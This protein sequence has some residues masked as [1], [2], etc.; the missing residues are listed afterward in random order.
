MKVLFSQNPSSSG[1]TKR[2]EI[3]RGLARSC[4]VRDFYLASIRCSPIACWSAT[5]M[6]LGISPWPP[7]LHA[8]STGS[9]FFTLGVLGPERL[10]PRLAL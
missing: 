5:S 6:H 8:P 7:D 9:T 10:G 2:F 1:G 3:R 4:L